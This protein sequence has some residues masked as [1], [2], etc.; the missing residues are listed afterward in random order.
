M[1]KSISFIG[2]LI[3]SIAVLSVIQ[4]IVSNRLSTTGLFLGNLQDEIKI[5]KT[6]SSMLSEK[7]LIASS[8]ENISSGAANLGFTSNASRI[9]FTGS[10]PLAVKQ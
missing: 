6:D 9:V 4:V 3:L 5:Y 1:K 8:L 10:I 2:F 7:L